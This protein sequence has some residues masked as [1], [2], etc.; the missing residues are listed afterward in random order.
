M[1]TSLSCKSF[2]NQSSK[3]N[4]FHG[5]GRNTQALPLGQPSVSYTYQK[6]RRLFPSGPSSLAACCFIQEQTYLNRI[7]RLFM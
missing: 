2:S 3:Q 7:P 1:E 6:R 5:C 4:N